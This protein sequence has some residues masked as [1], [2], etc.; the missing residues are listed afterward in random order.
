M[1]EHQLVAVG[2]TEI[3]GVEPFATRSGRP[4]VG[5]AEFHRLLVQGVDLGTAGMDLFFLW[6]GGSGGYDGAE[7]SGD[8]FSDVVQRRDDGAG[9]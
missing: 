7:V 1:K 2:I 8:R 9:S 5:G 3:A 4:F 6:A